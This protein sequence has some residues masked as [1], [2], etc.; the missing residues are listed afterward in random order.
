MNDL[1]QA[2]I[3]IK[4]SDANLPDFYRQLTEGELWFLVPYH[5]E[6]EGECLELNPGSP[7]PFVMLEDEK[8][9]VV[10]LFSSEMRVEE[11]LKNANIP[12]RTHSA[13]AMP[14]MSV[15]E[16]LGKADVRAVLNKLCSTGQVIIP[17]NLM[18]DLADGSALRPQSQGEHQ[19]RI[20]NI[21]NPADYPTHLIQAAFESM[22]RHQNFRAAWVFTLAEAKP[23]DAQSKR[24]QIVVLMD[25]RDEK[26]L[27]DLNMTVQGARLKADDVGIG[28][29]D[30]T[31]RD[32]IKE[33]FRKARPFY[34]AADF[35]AVL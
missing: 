13:G 34:V 27:H 29:L 1:D 30:E 12:A 4:R 17:P 14:A 5:P 28:L 3:A 7:L 11:A 2:I 26:V 6:V 16:I 24:F 31:D 35:P 15:L 21:V 23:N 8:G 19:E 18:R 9:V 33:L 22:R 32:Y 25:P 10:P 20:I